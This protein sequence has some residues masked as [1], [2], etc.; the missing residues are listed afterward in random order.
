MVSNDTVINVLACSKIS[1]ISDARGVHSIRSSGVVKSENEA[2]NAL[3]EN[4]LQKRK[5]D[6][7]PVLISNVGTN[8]NTKL[9]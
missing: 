8:I 4:N 3:S 2:R 7:R 9:L 1:K 6:F 5:F